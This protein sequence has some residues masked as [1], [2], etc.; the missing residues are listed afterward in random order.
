MVFNETANCDFILLRKTC[1]RH[2]EIK[3]ANA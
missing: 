3:A 2:F 1:Q